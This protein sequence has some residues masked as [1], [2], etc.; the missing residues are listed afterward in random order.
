MTIPW[1]FGGVLHLG[2]GYLKGER[3]KSTIMLVA[4]GLM[5]GEGV[6]QLLLMVSQVFIRALKGSG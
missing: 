1:A 5:L 2:W 4:S 3:G 6:T